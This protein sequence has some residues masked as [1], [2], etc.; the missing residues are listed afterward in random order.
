MEAD[1]ELALKMETDAFGERED[2]AGEHSLEEL[3]AV[4]EVVCFGVCL[5]VLFVE[6]EPVGYGVSD[7]RWC[8]VDVGGACHGLADGGIELFLSDFDCSGERVG[9]PCEGVGPLID[10]YDGRQSVDGFVLDERICIAE[11]LRV[12]AVEENVAAV[13]VDSDDSSPEHRDLVLS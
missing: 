3:K 2:V 10:G 7:G 1:I 6:R 11:A 12:V 8:E 9:E 4:S 13:V 5:I